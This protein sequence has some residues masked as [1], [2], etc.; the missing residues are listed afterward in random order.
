MTYLPTQRLRPLGYALVGLALWACRP[1]PAFNEPPAQRTSRYKSELEQTLSSAPY[2]WSL[3]YYP[4]VDSLLFRNPTATY[5]STRTQPDSYGYGGYYFCVRFGANKM[6]ELKSDF[7]LEEAT[8]AQQGEYDIRLGNSVQ[9]SFTTHTA[10]HRLVN[11]ELGGVADLVYRYRDAEG[12]LIFATGKSE[13]HSRA[14]IVL[15]PLASE[16]AWQTATA[17]AV[18][19]RQYFERMT[20]PQLRIRWGNRLYYRSDVPFKTRRSDL[21]KERERNRKRYHLFLAYREPLSPIFKGYYG[22]GSGYVGTAEGLSLRPGFAYSAEQVFY[23]FERR[24]DKFV[25]ELVRTY[26]PLFRK[27]RYV[28]RHLAHEGEPT[29]LVAEISDSPQD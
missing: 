22:I 1:E 10:W 5:Q 11:E 18:E 6:L 17:K 21:S 7:S 13:E 4:K 14:Y 9:L 26:D 20:R 3:T 16:E 23:D 27:F 12:N 25:A 28:S 15:K 19:N 29:H 2:G 8:T 24:G